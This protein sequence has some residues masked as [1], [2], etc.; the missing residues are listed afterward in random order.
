[1][2]EYLKNYFKKPTNSSSGTTV[3]SKAK[4]N[5]MSTE[6]PESR[7]RREKSLRMSNT[8]DRGEQIEYYYD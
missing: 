8:E 4:M 1:V 3:F 6:Y 5:G 2:T 7:L